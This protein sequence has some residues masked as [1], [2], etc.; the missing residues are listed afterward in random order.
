MNVGPHTDATVIR[1]LF[2]M[3]K[4]NWKIAVGNLYKYGAISIS[5][6]PEERMLSIEE[7]IANDACPYLPQQSR[8]TTKFSLIGFQKVVTLQSLIAV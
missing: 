5:K 7:A 2:Q 4:A 6:F 3:S 1:E 8:T